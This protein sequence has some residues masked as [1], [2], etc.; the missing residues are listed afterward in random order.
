MA[1]RI[2]DKTPPHDDE[3]ER[4]TLGS[5]LE[6]AEAVSVAIQ[7]HIHPED[8]YSR[9]NQ[10]IYEAVLSLDGKG[11]RPDIQTVVQELKHLGKLDEAGGASYV[12]GLT[13]VIPSSANIDYYAQTVKNYSLKRS[14]LKVASQ[15]GVSAYD[16]SKEARETLEE[17]QQYIF[18][19]SDDRQVFSSRKIGEVLKE[20]I[21]IID[22]VRE[23]KNPITGISSGLEKLDQMTAG[24]QKDEFIII[25][26]RPS[27]GKTALALN[28]AA[29]IAFH[30]K[31]PTAFFSLEMSSIA[32]V[33]R[34]ISS[35]ALVQ[36]QNLRSG[37]LSSGDYKK[38][39]DVMGIIY[40]AP[41][42]IV[43]MPNMKLLDLRSQARKLRSQQQVEIIFIDYLGLIGHDN[44]SLPRYEQISEISRSL[45]SLARELHIPVV[46]LCQLNRDAQFEVPTLANLRD[47]GSIEQ[48][49]DLVL[50]LNREVPK[51]K[52]NEKEEEKQ[53]PID[54]IPTDLIIAKQRNGPTGVVKLELVTKYAKFAPL[55]KEQTQ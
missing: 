10:R 41:F 38:I 30:K 39:I 27:V 2:R 34:L 11:L 26:A 49:A 15:I 13:T 17:I 19:L 4:A 23:S 44:G 6:D 9:A 8:F 1:G 54:L 31:I 18:E 46:V 33:Q 37:F 22:Q 16:E 21:D 20:T 48:D 40:E 43:D 24:F 45:K 52:K 3:L 53:G 14:L 5:L 28:M 42:H 25:G 12:S 47:S 51:K 36:A 29:N 7:Q 50:F 32:L 35:E 55:S